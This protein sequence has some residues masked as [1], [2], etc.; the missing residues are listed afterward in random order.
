MDFYKEHE[1]WVSYAETFGAGDY[2]E[3]IVQDAYI[4][5]IEKNIVQ[6]PLF[7]ITLRNMVMDFH[8]QNKRNVVPLPENESISESLFEY[9]NRWYWYDRDLYLMYIEKQM[10]LREIS[11]ATNISLASVHKTIKHCNEKLK[12]WYKIYG[13]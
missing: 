3:D 12:Q 1:K 6:T 13:T 5:A 2:A 9:I 10:T 8:R 11:E 7:Y 4:K